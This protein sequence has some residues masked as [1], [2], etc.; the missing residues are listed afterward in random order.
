[1]E[2]PIKTEV[3][4]SS[5]GYQVKF[6]IGHQTFF[7]REQTE[8]IALNEGETI[9]VKEYSEWYKKQLDHAFENLINI[10][11]NEK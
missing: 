5:N 7:L 10:I 1:M 4:K 3:V 2:K 6:T 8:E 9:T 11:K